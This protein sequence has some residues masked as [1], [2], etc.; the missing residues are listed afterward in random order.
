M[1]DSQPSSFF[2]GASSCGP[3]QVFVLLLQLGARGGTA[4]RFHWPRLVYSFF[5]ETGVF[6]CTDKSV[7]P[8]STIFFPR[9]FLELFLCFLQTIIS[10]VHFPFF[11]GGV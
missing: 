8:F 7:T 5:V 6:A 11:G 1:D 3:A 2:T 4:S 9:G 10:G